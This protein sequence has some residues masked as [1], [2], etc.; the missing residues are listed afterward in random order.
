MK[1]NPKNSSSENVE[2]RIGYSEG[3]CKKG[4]LK[5]FI[6]FTG[7]NLYQGRFFNKAAGL[8]LEPLF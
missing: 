1:M 5:N 3:F 7:K 4:V 6:K 2:Y 8:R